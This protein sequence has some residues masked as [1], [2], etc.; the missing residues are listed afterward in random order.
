YEPVKLDDKK[1]PSPEK[2]P[3]ILILDGGEDVNPSMYGQKNISSHFSDARDAAEFALLRY[4]SNFGKRMSG[5]CRGHQ[6]LNVYFGGSLIQDIRSSKRFTEDALKLHIGGH[7]VRL[8]RPYGRTKFRSYGG[9]IKKLNPLKGS[10]KRGHIISRFVG[11]NPF[12]VSSMHHQAIKN[13]GEGLGV[14][15]SFGGGKRGKYYI[16]EGIESSNGKVRG[17]QSH[18]EFS[19]YPKDG[20]MF[21]YLMHV[22]KFVDNL[23]EPDMAEIEARLRDGGV[24]KKLT[25]PFDMQNIPPVRTR[26]GN[27]EERLRD[28]RITERGIYNPPPPENAPVRNVRVDPTFTVGNTTA[29]ATWD[30][31]DT[32]NR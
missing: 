10:K 16:V 8:K 29:N 31:D 25:L 7:K 22:D 17:I 6:L 24:A 12:T 5:I 32:N 18:P 20:A 26:R 1:L 28:D 15:L 3:D 13:L 14:S 27:R 30:D 4:F 19:G 9:H 2:T 11:I 23:S 21:S